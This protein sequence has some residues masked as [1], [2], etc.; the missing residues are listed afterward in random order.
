MGKTS[1]PPGRCEL[2][3]VT[4]TYGDGATITAHGRL[5]TPRR[6]AVVSL[7]ENRG[8]ITH[9]A[10]DSLTEEEAAKLSDWVTL[11]SEHGGAMPSPAGSMGPWGSQDPTSAFR[12]A[13]EDWILR[14][15]SWV[16]RL[17][18]PAVTVEPITEEGRSWIEAHL[19]A[20]RRTERLRDKLEA[21][22]PSLAREFDEVLWRERAA[23]RSEERL[24]EW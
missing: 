22:D 19:S 9:T 18:S 14:E 4:I 16:V 5:S 10:S 1:T 6:Q 2:A 12:L 21:L 24:Q 7:G 15:S 11:S 3:T 13:T 20:D 23:T 17:D 8:V